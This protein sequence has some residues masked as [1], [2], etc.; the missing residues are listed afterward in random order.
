MGA[1]SSLAH[2]KMRALYEKYVN[3]QDYVIFRLLC[4]KDKIVSELLKVMDK[5][6]TDQSG[7]S[8]FYIILACLRLSSSCDRD[9]SANIKIKRV[10]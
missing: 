7:L 6:D 1:A 2:K 9:Y 8:Q 4:I 5:M 10:S 3:E